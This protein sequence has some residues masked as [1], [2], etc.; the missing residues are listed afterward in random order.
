MEINPRPALRDPERLAALHDLALLDTAPEE[1]FDRYTRLL[2]NLLQVPVA[3]ISFVDEDRQFFKSYQGLG[4]PW[5]SQQQTPLSHSFCQY[6]VALRQPLI[7]MDARANPLLCNNLAI[8]DLE[9]IAYAGMPLIT[10]AG[11]ALGSLC[12]IDSEPREWQEGELGTLRDLAAALMSEIE[13]RYEIQSREQLQVALTEREQFYRFLAENSADMLARHTPEGIFLY[14]SPASLPLV[15]YE[16]DELVGRSIYEF[17]HPDDLAAIQASH[18]EILERPDIVTVSYRFQ[19]KDGR[20]IWFE[21][22]SRQIRNPQ[23]GEVEEIHATSR[24]ISARRK[25]EDLKGEFV[26]IV[27]HELR[28]PLTSIQGSL[29]LLLGGV[30]GNLPDPALDMLNIA[31]KNSARLVHLINDILDIEKIETGKMR[32]KQRPHRLLHLMEQVLE[33]NQGFAEQYGVRLELDA[34]P[35]D[36]RVSVDEERLIQVLTNLLSNAIKF[37]PQGGL[38]TLLVTKLDE[39]VRVSVIDR[40]PGIPEEFQDRI[41]QKFAQ[42]DASST[43]NRG[44]SGLGLNIARALIEHM[45]GQIGYESEV[46]EGTTFYIELPLYE[47][48]AETLELKDPPRILIC[49]SNPDIVAV[50]RGS[51]EQAGFIVDETP[52]AAEARVMLERQEY[53]A[54]TLDLLLPDKQGLALV[55]ELRET[56]SLQHMPII[57]ISVSADVVH[58]T[59][60]GGALGFVNWLDK[61]ID[62][63]QLLASVRQ[64]VWAGAVRRRDTEKAHILHVEDD[65]DLAHLVSIILREVAEVTSVTS[66]AQAVNSL[67]E[68]T[69]DVLLLDIGLQDGS[70]LELLSFL[71]PTLPVVIFSAWQVS[72]EIVEEVAAALVKSQ[73]SAE[74][75]VDTIRALVS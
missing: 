14:S 34:P 56:E 36:C 41:F 5:A 55:R 29:G 48:E 10:R 25:V 50:L 21:T 44:G 74:E 1:T 49:E 19:R 32:F 40:G 39:R 11:H 68:Q 75:L 71:P 46:G 58:Q 47:S 8:P 31:Y 27:S 2:R 42:A 52:T 7:V 23:S 64:A 62:R 26:S 35:A 4:E 33:A 20:Y 37:S 3:L 43:R 30:A 53:V 24:D 70:G 66:L 9:V 17:F 57:V 69:F 65:S 16:P 73:T 51:L 38:V 72:E 12:A 15:G 59:L 63:A 6:V 28:T 54:M 22:T 60:N 61:P 67:R 18:N 45:D 13:L